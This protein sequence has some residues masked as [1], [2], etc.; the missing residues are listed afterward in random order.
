MISELQPTSKTLMV[1]FGAGDHGGGPTKEN[2]RSIERLRSEAGAPAVLYSIPSRY[3]AEIQKS[4]VPDV[5]LIRDELQHHAVGGY[6]NVSEFKKSNRTAEAVLVT[7]EKPA[8][9]G[10]AAWGATYPNADFTSAWER[11][12]FQYF[13]DSINGVSVPEHYEVTG[14]EGYTI[15][16][17]VARHAMYKAAERLAW[18][19]PTPRSGLGVPGGVQS[20]RHGG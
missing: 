9:V 17:Y 20:G 16:L 3:F 11:V 1:F 2:I 4:G 15:A 18:E 19:A 14:R 7:S 8:A 6:T 10:A 12:L 13:H 5:P